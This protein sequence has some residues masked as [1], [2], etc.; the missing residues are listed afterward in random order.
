M[1]TMFEMVETLKE[2]L[3]AV[4]EDQKS[5]AKVVDKME[6]RHQMKVN[7]ELSKE[8]SQMKDCSK[9]MS[10]VVQKDVKDEV[11]KMQRK[12]GQV[13]TG[14]VEHDKGE[15]LLSGCEGLLLARRVAKQVEAVVIILLRFIKANKHK[16]KLVTITGSK[17]PGRKDSAF[18]KINKFLSTLGE[19]LSE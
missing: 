4:D 7:K 8:I 18:A 11:E 12:T 14:W 13:N 10:K 16:Q 9:N 19:I 15:Q 5:T 2:L 3:I 1:K 17:N 6:E